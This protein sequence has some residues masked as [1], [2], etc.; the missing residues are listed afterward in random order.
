[1]ETIFEL[2][3]YEVPAWVIVLITV[4][5]GIVSFWSKLRR[6]ALLLRDFNRRLVYW[7]RH[8]LRVPSNEAV[9]RSEAVPSIVNITQKEYDAL[10]SKDPNT[11]YLISEEPTAEAT[12]ASRQND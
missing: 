1:M 6:F 7:I 3:N 9:V 8:W 4:L 2:V 11:L 12:R 10:P 5:N